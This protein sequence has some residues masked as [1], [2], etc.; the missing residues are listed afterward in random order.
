MARKGSWL[1]KDGLV[2]N[3]GTRT[4]TTDVATTL[5]TDMGHMQEIAFKIADCT[6]LSTAATGGSG[7]YAPQYIA[8]ASRIPANAT[9]QEVWITTEVACATTAGTGDLLLG[10]YTVNQTT[11]AVTAVNGTNSLVVAGDTATTDFDTVGETMVIGKSGGGSHLGK[12]TVGSSSVIVLPVY[13]TNAFTAGALSVRVR[14][15]TPVN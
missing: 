15:T 1:N 2:V 12:Q 9:V 14:Y 5:A 3:F 7:I 8:Q 11:K 4:K 6:L 13:V 10:I